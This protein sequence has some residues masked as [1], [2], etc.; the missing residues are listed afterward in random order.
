MQPPIHTNYATHQQYRGIGLWLRNHV[1]P[2]AN[3]QVSGEIGTVA[4]YAERRLADGF[5]CRIG[6]RQI[7]EWAKNMT[8]LQ[9][10]IVRAN[11]YWLRADTACIPAKYEL[12]MYGR[13]VPPMNVLSRAIKSWDINSNWVLNGSVVLMRSEMS[14]ANGSE[15]VPLQEPS[16]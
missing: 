3:V 10:V 11:F 12:H 7:L 13:A 4:F 6:N 9:G 14:G 5:S 2:D 16:P 15:T 8:G 1:E